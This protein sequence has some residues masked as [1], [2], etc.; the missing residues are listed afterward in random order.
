MSPSI[1]R[2]V[3]YV[4]PSTGKHLPAIVT[5]VAD[6]E[7][8]DHKS[9]DY[10]QALALDRNRIDLVVFSNL[11]PSFSKC[12][13]LRDESAHPRQHSWHWPEREP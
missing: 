10:R 2:I 1:G 4:E 5:R 9:T 7:K 8:V 13:V 11:I 3:H 12:G 6:S